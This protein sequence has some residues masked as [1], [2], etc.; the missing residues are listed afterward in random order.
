MPPPA[1]PPRSLPWRED[2][3]GKCIDNCRSRY[4]IPQKLSGSSSRFHRAPSAT[5]RWDNAPHTP[6]NPVFP[7]SPRTGSGNIPPCRSGSAVS[8]A[9]PE[10]PAMPR[11]DKERNSV[12]SQIRICPVQKT[13]AASRSPASRIAVLPVSACC[14]D[15]AP[16]TIR[17]QCICSEN[18]PDCPLPA[19]SPA[20]EMVVPAMF[21][22]KSCRT[23][24]RRQRLRRRSAEIPVV[25]DRQ[26]GHLRRS[27]GCRQKWL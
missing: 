26:G 5:L 1:V 20:W 17:R 15:N 10:I 19:A 22:A 6:R 13:T 3:W 2:G 8:G 25:P 27:S 11:W 16:C 12:C 14:R 9:M 18:D 7:V 24:H 21:F 23:P 4:R